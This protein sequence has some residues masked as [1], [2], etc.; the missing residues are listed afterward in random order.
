MNLLHLKTH[1]KAVPSE[2]GKVKISGYASTND[3]DRAGDVILPTAWK[4]G[5]G[6]YLKN[7]ILL[8]NHNY[9]RPIG[10]ATNIHF[11]DKG[12]QIDGEIIEAEAANL[13]KNDVLKAFSVGFMIKDA[14]YDSKTDVFVIKEAELYEISVVSV[15]CNQDAVFSVSKSFE[16][17]SEYSEFKKQFS[18]VDTENSVNTQVSVETNN[19]KEEKKMELKDIEAMLKDVAAE[20]AKSLL[21]AQKE[22]A[23]AAAKAADEAKVKKEALHV[24]V[25]TAAERL[26]ADVEKRFAEKNESL[27][28]IVNELKSELTSK[29]AEIDKMRESKRHFSDRSS[30][31]TDWKKEFEVD[32]SDAFILGLATGKGWDTSRAK[33]LMEKVNAHSGIAVSSADFEQIV[34]SNIERDIQNALVLAPLF[35]EIPMTSASM[36]LPIMPDSG[37]AEFVSTQVTDATAPKGNLDQRS[38]AYGTEAGI[39]LAE[40]SLTT[41]KLVSLS[42]MGNETDEDAIIPILGLL[43]DAMVRSH[44]RA[45]EQAILAGNSADGIYGTSGASFDGLLSL[46]AADSDFT[47]PTGTYAATDVVTAADLMTLRKNMGKYGLRPEDVIYIVSQ[48]A[49]FNLLEDSEFQDM[50]LVGA[51]STKVKGSIGNVYGSN[52]IV[53]DEFAAKAAGKFGAIAVN[54]RNYLIPRLRGLTIESAYETANQRRV[55]VATQRLGFLDLIDGATS[56]WGFKYKAAA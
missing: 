43:R 6:N 51:M 42:Y 1:L 12:L 21:A 9:D 34:S 26:F 11:D 56:K 31:T 28:S 50:N 29:S 41:K 17:P 45:V 38:A 54:P 25:T 7:P 10:K 53:C 47:Q 24:E 36:I 8:F 52:V 19:K 40:R 27:E 49:Y 14:D 2:D 23:A 16:T 4:S 55:L 30:S 39:A 32:M 33:G 15:P 37:Y 3:K 22:E 18:S 20:T 44:A 5:I 46:A 48:D 35:R 13:I